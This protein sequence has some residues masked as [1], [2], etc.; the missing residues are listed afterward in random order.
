MFPEPDMPPADTVTQRVLVSTAPDWQ[1]ISRWYWKLSEPHYATTPEMKAKVD[2][3]VK[4]AGDDTK[5]IQAVFDWVS[6]EVRYLGITAEAEAPGYEPHDVA[7]TFS[8]RHGV[9]RDKAALLA[10][11]LRSGRIRGLSGSH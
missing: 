3:L 10:A 1:T 9:C 11:M 7:A 6:H 5:K 2:E 4:G 8:R